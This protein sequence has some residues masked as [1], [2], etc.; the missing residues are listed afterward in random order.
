MLTQLYSFNWYLYNRE[1]PLLRIICDAIALADED[2]LIRLRKSFAPLVLAHEEKNWDKAPDFGNIVPL[3]KFDYETREIISR[4]ILSPKKGSF[5]WYIKYS[6]SFVKAMTHVIL[7][8]KNHD[9]LKKSYPQM[10][11]AYTMKSWNTPPLAFK[12]DVYNSDPL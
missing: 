12:Q 3:R 11:A 9:N 10:V 6:G 1:Y 2:N 4:P 8:S 5:G 7:N